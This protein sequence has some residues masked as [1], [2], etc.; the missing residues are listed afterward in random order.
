MRTTSRFAS[1]LIST[2]CTPITVIIGGYCTLFFWAVYNAGNSGAK[3]VVEWRSEDFLGFLGYLF[4]AFMLVT[5]SVMPGL[6]A[7]MGLEHD[8]HGDALILKALL[9]GSFWLFFPIIWLGSAQANSFFCPMTASLFRSFF[10]KFLIWIQFY[11]ATLTIVAVPFVV[12]HII[13]LNI[14][15]FFVQITLKAIM[16]TIA[17]VFYGLL[18]GRLSWI[19]DDELRSMDFDD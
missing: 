8:T 3:R 11:F 1:L 6:L 18:L 16:F 5:A 12:S 14:D 19:L 15:V 4:W 13:N 7:S 17:V 10:S 2:V 9:A